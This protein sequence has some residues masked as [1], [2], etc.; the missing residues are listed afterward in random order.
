MDL[1]TKKILITCAL[2][3]VIIVGATGVYVATHTHV[4]K[5]DFR[6]DRFQLALQDLTSM[7]NIDK[8]TVLAYLKSKNIN[9]QEFKQANKEYKGFLESGKT[10]PPPATFGLTRSDVENIIENCRI[11]GRTIKR[12]N[13]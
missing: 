1:Y 2:A 10:L 3:I 9:A 12:I 6:S 7:P 5:M 11:R 4:E 13:C 8:A